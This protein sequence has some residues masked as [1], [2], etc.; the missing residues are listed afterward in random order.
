MIQTFRHKGVE[1]FFRSGSRAGIQGR[2]VTL[3]IPRKNC[4]N[5]R[6]HFYLA[7]FIDRV[8]HDTLIGRL[9]K[10]IDDVGVIRLVRAYLDARI[11]DG[12]VMVDRHWLRG[13][14]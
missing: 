10:R 4:P 12:G 13:A 3:F 11:M 8:N 9:K 5:E 1:R 6:S 2:A 7:K 14:G